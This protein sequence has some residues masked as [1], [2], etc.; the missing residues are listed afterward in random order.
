MAIKFIQDAVA[1]S[2]GA[3]TTL[4]ITISPAKGNTL[5]VQS[6]VAGAQTITGITDNTGLN[7]YTKA[8]GVTNTVT[9]EVWTSINVSAGVTTVTV[10]YSA[11]STGNAVVVSEYFGVGNIGTN[12]TNTGTASTPETISLT[13]S[14]RTSYVVSSLAN[15]L[16][17]TE[18]VTANTG[19]LRDHT[20]SG[21]GVNTVQT[22]AADNTSDPP[23]SV[24]TSANLGAGVNWAAAAVELQ[25][26]N[27]QGITVLLAN[28]PTLP[29]VATSNTTGYVTIGQTWARL[30][31]QEV[32]SAQTIAR[33]SGTYSRLY[34]RVSTNTTTTI[35]ATF[36]FRKNTANGN[37]VIS[38]PVGM[39]GEFFTTN[40]SD[41]VVSGDLIDLQFIVANGAAAVT[42]DIGTI[43][44]NSNDGTTVEH[45][46]LP[47]TG[48]NQNFNGV[49]RFYTIAGETSG[50]QTIESNT[51][52]VFRTPGTLKNFY[53]KVAVNS[54][55][56]TTTMGTRINTANGAQSV[57]VGAGLTGIFED[58]VHTDAIIFGTLGDYFTTF[59]AEA[60]TIQFGMGSSFVTLTNAYHFLDWSTGSL[61]VLKSVTDNY[62][63]C[64]GLFP[65]PT[66]SLLQTLSQIPMTLSYLGIRVTANTVTAASTLRS[67]INAANGNQV[68]SITAS[69]TGFFEDAVN[70][71]VLAGT[72]EI[73][74]QLIT[75]GTGTSLAHAGPALLVTS[76]A[77]PTIGSGANIRLLP[78]TGIGT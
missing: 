46:A 76:P 57:S 48:A 23:I 41:S 36:K 12:G 14:F 66:E 13:T 74:T 33:I 19:T 4:A 63:I 38:I 20:A 70:T 2:T 17:S 26:P 11:A 40:Q 67:R 54:R 44:F 35:P 18:T 3:T 7:T 59:G 21:A 45:F 62:P 30:G 49:T 52:F 32:T 73:N 25:V 69:T 72:E 10:T 71:D 53:A 56:T 31:N 37:Q 16:G 60:T 8:A 27:F 22:A 5:V 39:I 34:I 78:I 43:Q 64:G 6:G 1:N 29:F 28:S 58:L 65:G 50:A 15:N 77:T 68:V 75:G 61:V 24:T 9:A 42:Y 55:A 47:P 51:Q